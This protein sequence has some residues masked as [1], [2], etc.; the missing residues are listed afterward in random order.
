MPSA[1]LARIPRATRRRVLLAGG[2]AVAA[3]GT[4]G[5]TW[6]AG[7]SPRVRGLVGI[8]EPVQDITALR[9]TEPPA[10]L[11]KADL[12]DAAG[13]WHALTSFAGKGIVLNFWATWCAPCVGEMPALARLA[14]HVE[15]DGIL[16]LAAA[17]DDGGAAAVRRFFAQR[18]IDGLQIWLDPNGAAGLTLGTH[19]ITPT[20]LIIDRSGHEKA[21]LQGPARWDTGEAAAEIR[22]LTG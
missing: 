2:A 22:R 3:A 8:P 16:V 11:P 20:T 18:E 15:Q 7:T 1:R 17:S 9:R 10:E 19:G 14:R 21:R 13:V 4:A 6:R 5:L 12:M